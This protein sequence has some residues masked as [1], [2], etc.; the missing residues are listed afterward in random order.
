VFTTHEGSTGSTK[1]P[2]YSV[3]IPA[4]NASG[5]LPVQLAALAA[6]SYRGS[7]EVIV[8]DNG[9]SDRTREIALEMY[10]SFPSLRVVDA[11]ERRGP[12]H[13]RNVGAAAARGEYVCFVD[14]D[15]KVAPTWLEEIARATQTSEIV[16]GRLDAYFV[17][18][19]GEVVSQRGLDGLSTHD[20]RFLGNVGSGNLCV[21]RSLFKALHGFDEDFLT[22][23]DIDFSWRAQLAGQRIERAREAVVF[24]RQRTSLHD[25][26]MQ[27]FRYGQAAPNL[28]AKFRH[29]GMPRSSIREAAVVWGKC[30]VAIVWTWKTKE[31]RR[32]WV[33][34]VAQRSGRIMGSVKYGVLYL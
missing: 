22:G 16:G 18:D 5:H 12:A 2:R 25:I 31:S 6:Q 7:W 13:A 11:S 9:S 32:N 34:A 23:E 27:Y 33:R 24:Y 29:A 19:Q 3:V 30:I 28:F 15:D 21:R 26:A 4:K 14:A 8:A 20:F 10:G 1:A 17:D